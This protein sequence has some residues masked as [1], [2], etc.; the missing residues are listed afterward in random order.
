M[1]VFSLDPVY[2]HILVSLSIMSTPL[3]IILYQ[4][5]SWDVTE[6]SALALLPL[7]G[8]LTHWQKLVIMDA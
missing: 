8:A 7:M 1:G 2:F 3:S 6:I 5:H 4:Q